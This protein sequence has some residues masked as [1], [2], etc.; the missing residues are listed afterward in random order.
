MQIFSDDYACV[1][2]GAA[3]KWEEF[4]STPEGNLFCSQCWKSMDIK[5]EAKR[6]CP[7]DGID[8]DKKIIQGLAIIDS[9]SICG[10]SWFDKDEFRVILKVAE[11]KGVASFLFDF[12]TSVI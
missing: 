7:V 3:H 4:K 6:K 8:M 1:R 10:G 5:N 2:C 12:L 9:C 11:E